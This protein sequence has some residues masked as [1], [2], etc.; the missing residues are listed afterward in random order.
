MNVVNG[1]LVVFFVLE[2]SSVTF[3]DDTDT[4]YTVSLAS[5]A[6]KRLHTS[7]NN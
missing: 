5:A 2:P 3:K 7:D 4:C 6:L 1:Q